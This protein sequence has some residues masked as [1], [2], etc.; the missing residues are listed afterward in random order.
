V[1][2]LAYI[3][4]KRLSSYHWIAIAFL[5]IS[6][7]RLWI[8]WRRHAFLFLILLLLT[9]GRALASNEFVDFS[10]TYHNTGTNTFGEECA[11]AEVT[12]NSGYNDAYYLG[13]VDCPGGGTVVIANTAQV[14][15]GEPSQSCTFSAGTTAQQVPITTVNFTA[16]DGVHSVVTGDV[17]VN[18]D[19]CT[20][21]APP[22]Y[23]NYTFCVHNTDTVNSYGAYWIYNGVPVQVVTLAPG[24]SDCWTTPAIEVSP[25]AQNFT[26]NYGETPISNVLTNLFGSD[27]NSD[28]APTIGFS[29]S[30]GGAGSGTGSGSGTNQITYSG[31]GGSVTNSG[32]TNTVINTAPPTVY[33]PTN[34]IV[35]S[36]SGTAADNGTLTSGF[37]L[38][39]GDLV[40]LLTAD[41][42]LN[43]TIQNGFFSVTNDLGDIITYNYVLSNEEYQV[44]SAV[45]N[46]A[47]HLNPSNSVAGGSSNVW[48]QNFPTNSTLTNYATETTLVGISNILAQTDTNGFL[49]TNAGLTVTGY[50]NA[51]DAA[52][53]AAALPDQVAADS[54]WDTFISSITGPEVDDVSSA[55]SMV[56]T[57]PA[58]L[59]TIDF[60][61][62]DN[63]AAAAIFTWVKNLFMWL[64][65]AIYLKRC[66]DD[67][68][69]VVQ[70][71][72]VA[73]GVA[74]T[75]NV[76]SN[77]SLSS[78]TVEGILL[79]IL[80]WIKQGLVALFKYIVAK[81]AQ[82]AVALTIQVAVL[83]AWSVFLGVFFTGLTG[84]GLAAVY[85]TSPVSGI[86]SD[87]LFL[88]C[89]CF[90]LHFAIGLVEA[91]ITFKFT[92]G[93]AAYAMSRTVKFLFGG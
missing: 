56:Y 19:T 49:D 9:V 51:T 6:L 47:A 44:V 58:D 7:V 37:N 53:A 22:V 13:S 61:P 69:A 89:S 85:Q 81:F 79:Q 55:S 70:V 24:Q 16:H 2:G 11:A 26:I 67:S 42:V 59:G 64:L 72:N 29:P 41:S 68:F 66:A 73:H 4:M 15:T 86:S 75:N 28:V 62:M 65:A 87:V 40:N 23:T 27:T 48:V 10:I 5:V 52:A 17:Y 31:G 63:S 18:G 3:P 20:V 76:S 60:N 80:A 54:S 46:L 78:V 14:F 32:G 36:S 8:Y 71:M 21:A 12:W 93:H 91:Y 38:L 30:G 43:T 88:V 45:T 90:P 25:V 35:Y 74:P 77:F 82:A 84:L 1:A 83:F 57:F 34:T 39:H 92:L 33:A 50:T